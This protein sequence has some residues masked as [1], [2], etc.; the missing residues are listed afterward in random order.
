MPT[1]QMRIAMHELGH[2]WGLLHTNIPSNDLRFS[3]MSYPIS[4]KDAKIPLTSGMDDIKNLQS[5]GNVRGI[6][7]PAYGQSHAQDGNTTY[8]FKQDTADL[9]HG[10]LLAGLANADIKNYVM[11]LWDRPNTTDAVTGEVD[12]G[13]GVDTI[14]ASGMTTNVYITLENGEF[15]SIGSNINTAPT[16]GDNYNNKGDPDGNTDYN[17]GIAVGAEIENAKGGSGNDYLKGNDLHN[18]LTG[19]AGDDTLEGGNGTDYLFGGTGS[20]VYKFSGNYGV[21]IINDEDNVGRIEINGQTLYGTD[22][23][24]ESIYKGTSSNYTYIKVNN[25]DLLVLNENDHANLLLIQNWSNNGLNI[26]LADQ[27]QN[28]PQATLLLGDFKKKIDDAGTSGT[29]DDTYVI[30]S[31]NYVRDTSQGDGN[32]TGALDLIT[33]TAG[34]DVID[35]K[36][37]DDALSGK[38]GDDYLLGGIGSDYIL[39]GLGKDTIVGGSGDDIIYGSGDGDISYPTDINF[40]HPVNIYPHPQATGFNWISGYYTTYDNGV[41]AGYTTGVPRNELAG[42]SGNQIDGGDGNDFIAAGTGADIVHGGADN[43]LIHGMGGDDIL[44]GDTGNDIIYGDGNKETSTSVVWANPED[45]GKDVID[46]GDG[47][48]V[49]YGQGNDD[50]IF[51]G[52]DNDLI[53]GDGDGA[54]NTV[55]DY[56][57]YDIQ[58]NDY[59]DGGIG[60]DQIIGGGGNDTI[61]GGDG[62]DLI[63]GDDNEANLP[64]AYHGNDYLDGGIGNDSIYGGGGNDTLIGGTG[65]DLLSGGL[66]SDTIY[67]NIKEHDILAGSSDTTDHIILDLSSTSDITVTTNGALNAA[68]ILGSASVT[69]ASSQVNNG[70]VADSDSIYTAADGS[71]ITHSELLGTKLNNVVN[72]SSESGVLFGG[73]LDDYLIATGNAN[74]TLF[75][76]MGNDTLYGNIGNNILNGGGNDALVGDIGNDTL[77]GGLGDDYLYGGTGTNT[78]LFNRGYGSDS[79]Y[80]DGTNGVLTDIIK[81]GDGIS[82]T[83]I[84]LSRP[85]SGYANSLKLN[86]LGT[87]DTLGVLYF[88]F[89]D[90]PEQGGSSSSI[91]NNM[92]IQFADGSQ[93]TYDDIVSLIVATDNDDVLEGHA[94]GG[95]GLCR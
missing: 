59:L 87:T 64:V 4:Y 16:T 17:V 35:G 43:D 53:W 82:K 36:G 42:D 70:V 21:D 63:L 89:Q 65:A 44:F 31:G 71:Q 91:L 11:T 77:D 67:F 29:S 90:D 1:I 32:E 75:G 61:F 40:I 34:N 78:F 7:I 57:P 49:L 33:G 28:I 58:G 81:F 54:D 39:G 14:D 80:S 73:K 50:I 20:D 60:N 84:I 92:I 46:G 27:Q 62:N 5:G 55:G 41:I 48:D 95:G 24:F 47:N 79:V 66:G 6:D 2:V 15:S 38:A 51:G 45:H 19:N 56:T 85:T 18:E 69:N 26:N 68:V 25:G 37:G 3:I 12:T 10:N 9:G 74:S 83:D 86:I 93:W 94:T 30:E 22:Q 52:K 88:N 76:G 8:T 72:T 13:G 23:V